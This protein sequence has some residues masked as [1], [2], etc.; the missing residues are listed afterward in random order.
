MSYKKSSKIKDSPDKPINI[1]EDDTL[2][3]DMPLE[4]RL[5]FMANALNVINGHP[6]ISYPT[7]K[8]K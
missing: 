1:I 8:E 4:E 3:G 2:F 5:T 7:K 6:K